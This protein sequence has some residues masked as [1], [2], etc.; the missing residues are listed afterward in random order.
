VKRLSILTL[1]VLLAAAAFPAPAS[2][3]GDI[4]VS[5]GGLVKIQ[6]GTATCG[7]DATSRAFALGSG[8]SAFADTDSYAFA[9]GGSTAYASRGSTATAIAGSFASADRASRA[10][11]IGRSSASADRHGTA[12]AIAG[13]TANVITGETLTVINGR[14]R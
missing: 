4:C 2:A 12:T 5:I 6:S 8:S 7:S 10:T 1:P 11:A 13:S 3:A 14:V 9:S